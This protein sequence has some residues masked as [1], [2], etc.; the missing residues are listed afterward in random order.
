MIPY[1]YKDNMMWKFIDQ[2]PVFFNDIEYKLK[3]S[4]HLELLMNE[5]HN[6]NLRSMAIIVIG[7]MKSLIYLVI[8]LI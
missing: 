1:R 7:L 8:M 4:M 2:G 6:S 5:N 3:L